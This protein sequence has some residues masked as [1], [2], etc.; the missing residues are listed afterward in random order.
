MSIEMFT[1]VGVTEQVLMA[2]NFSLVLSMT[3][4]FSNNLNLYRVA[5]WA[6]DAR[7]EIRKTTKVARIV[8]GDEHD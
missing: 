2:K 7:N 5:A 3:V 6:E 4:Q 1:D 8:D